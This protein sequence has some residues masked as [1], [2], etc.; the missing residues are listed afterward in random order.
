MK[1]ETFVNINGERI[2]ID[3][4]GLRHGDQV[5]HVWEQCEGCGCAL[6]AEAFALL[7]GAGDHKAL[8]CSK[9]GTT[10]PVVSR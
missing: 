2:S 8:K 5:K 7:H 9:C 1:T 6:D 3:I 4:K 10:Y